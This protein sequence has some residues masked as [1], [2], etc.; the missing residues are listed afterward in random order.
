MGW[1]L[2]V[3]REVYRCGNDCSALPGGRVRGPPCPEHRLRAIRALAEA[4]ATSAGYGVL[5]LQPAVKAVFIDWLDRHAPGKKEQVRSRMRELR[6]GGLS[7]SEWGRRMRG[8]GL[9]AD[10]IEALFREG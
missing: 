1:F 9:W 8:D 6:G 4:G 10:Q 7:F 5:R 3:R 2:V